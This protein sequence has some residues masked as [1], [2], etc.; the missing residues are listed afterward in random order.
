MITDV[1]AD[2]GPWDRRPVGLD[3]DGLAGLLAPFGVSRIY[4]GRLEAL[5]F[6]DPHDAN[7]L[8]ERPAPGVVRVPVLDPTV[9]TW[10]DELDRLARAGP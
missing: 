10:S 4:A 3:A 1:C 2:L 6:E 8:G 5:W 7:R 9:A